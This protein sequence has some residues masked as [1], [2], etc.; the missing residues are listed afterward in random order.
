MCKNNCCEG[1]KC[2]TGCYT[3]WVAQ[4]LVI[5]GALNWGLVGLSMIINDDSS[6]NVVNAI[7]GSIPVLEA[8][9]YL[10]VAVSGIYMIT[11]FSSSKMN[12]KVN[13][14]NSNC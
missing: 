4:I 10:L 14:M 13:G 7:L 1:G 11:G 5:I 9:V 6:W 8:I 3:M 2:T 12:T